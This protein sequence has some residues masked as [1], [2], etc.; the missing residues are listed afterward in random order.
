MISLLK[1]NKSVYFW[2]MCI[3]Y[4]LF[5]VANK[6]FLFTDQ[7]YY[8]SLSEQ[9]TTEQIQR[10]LAFQNVAWRQTI[11]YIVIP[12]IIVI[13]V[14]YTSFCLYVGNLINEYRWGFGS[15][16]NISLKADIA[17]C[18]SSVCNFYYYAVSDNYKTIEDLGINCASLLKIINRESI[19]NWLIFAYNS[20]NVFELF[21]VFFLVFFIKTIFRI[22]Y[23]KSFIFVLLTYCIGNYLYV[24]GLTFLY[25]NFS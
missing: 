8:S 17:F 23:F 15:L 2:I 22:S 13:R 5:A 1:I 14:L 9:F 21:Y 10:V 12:L 3:I 7:L 24:V 16:Y 25:L 19:P 20:I 4:A 11:G 6:R 18:A